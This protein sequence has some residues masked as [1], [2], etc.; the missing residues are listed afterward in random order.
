MIVY[1]DYIIFPYLYMTDNCH[2]N[3]STAV[4]RVTIINYIFCDTIIIIELW[5]ILKSENERTNPHTHL[6]P[7]HKKKHPTSQLDFVIGLK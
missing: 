2:I 7:H 4:R 1:Q 3:D 6:P 5:K